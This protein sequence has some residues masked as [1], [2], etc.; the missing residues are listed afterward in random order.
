MEQYRNT[1]FI[2]NWFY[3]DG[4]DLIHPNDLERFKE[5]FR[6]HGNC[7]FFCVGEDKDYITF[8]YKEELFRVKPNLY[9]RVEMPI[10]SYG[11]YLKLKKYPDAICEVDDMRWHS[12]R[13]EPFY[14]IIVNSKKKSKRYYADEF[15]LE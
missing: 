9:K 15:L 8:K 14:T 13:S 10:Y 3:E 12:D 1:W 11:E 6:C 5:R 7:L 4:E 2:Y